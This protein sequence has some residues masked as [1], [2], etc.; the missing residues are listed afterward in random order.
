MCSQ[1]KYSVNKKYSGMLRCWNARRLFPNTK[2]IY[3]KSHLGRFQG[4][5]LPSLFG[6][7]A[8]KNCWASKNTYGNKYLVILAGCE[9]QN[10]T[11]FQLFW[12]FCLSN[13]KVILNRNKRKCLLV[14]NSVFMKESSGQLSAEA[15]SN[16][17]WG[18]YVNI[19]G[20]EFFRQDFFSDNCKIHEDLGSY[21]EIP[22]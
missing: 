16:K 10:S 21:L 6:S 18:Q 14:D 3:V 20:S 22:N 9:V 2:D 7:K 5:L 19:C 12:H 17:I 4:N 1:R 13:R 11:F 15:W 8:L